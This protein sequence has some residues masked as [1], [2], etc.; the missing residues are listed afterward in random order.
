M[1]KMDV[2]SF[3]IGK[4]LKVEELTD[5]KMANLLK[6]REIKA[7]KAKKQEDESTRNRE[8]ANRMRKEAEYKRQQENDETLRL[9]EQFQ[10]ED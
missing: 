2:I 4:K 7:N 10:L 1:H 8:E 3:G 6:W 5:D 9:I